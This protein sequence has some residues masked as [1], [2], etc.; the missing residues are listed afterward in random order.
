MTTLYTKPNCGQCLATHRL[1]DTQGI[2]HQTIDITQDAEALAAFKAQGFMSAPV[3]VSPIGTWAGFRP[4]RIA[5]L[6]ES[7]VA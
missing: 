7:Q 3:V 4:D 2:E 5:E 1:M 6:A